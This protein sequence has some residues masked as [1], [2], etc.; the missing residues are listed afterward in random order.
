MFERTKISVATAA[1]VAIL[2]VSS[3]ASAQEPD[4]SAPSDV[5]AP[6][7]A[8]AVTESGLASVVLHEGSGDRHPDA[9]SWVRVHYS[10]WTT[11]GELFDSSIQK[12]KS[13]TLPLDRLIAGWTE[14]LRLMVEGEK[15]R[16]WIPQEL[17]Y[18]GREDRPQGIL[19][20]DVE[21]VEIVDPPVAPDELTP[22]A[23]G[24]MHKKGLVSQLLQSGHG[25]RRPKA[26]STVTVL[27][28]G[29]TTDGEMFDTTMIQGVPA[30]F[31]LTGVIPGWTQGLQLMVEGEKRRFWIPEKLAYKGAEGK[32][33][34]MLVFDVELVAITVY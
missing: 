7:A 16:L 23:D 25:S 3:T 27:Y 14:G 1:W 4:L 10:G 30:T 5:A 17:A 20:F 31:P 15:R 8:A 18:A 29:W 6:P 22:P 13:M 33:Q 21:L 32:P 34:G 12:G 19:V 11:D 28:T 26:D 2:A 24:E 9:T